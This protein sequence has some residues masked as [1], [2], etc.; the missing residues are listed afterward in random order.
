[1]NTSRRITVAR[2]IY[3]TCMCF[4]LAGGIFLSNIL[5]TDASYTAG[6]TKPD[7]N[8]PS[9]EEVP[10]EHIEEPEYSYTKYVMTFTGSVNV[11]SMFG[12]RSYGTL[13][14]IHDE[15]GGAYFL[16]NMTE[17]TMNDDYTLAFLSSVFSDSDNLT[18]REKSGEEEIGWYRASADNTDILSLG[19]IDA[20]SLE[21]SG[22]KDYGSEG[23][24]D[25]KKAL[26][27]E[28]IAWGDSGKALYITQA[29]GVDIALY[30]CTYNTENVPGIISWIESAASARDYVAVMIRTSGTVNA[31]MT[32]DFH[33][34]IDAGADLIVAT[35]CKSI[36]AAENYG[37][38]Y[39]AYSLGSLIN[40]AEKYGDEYSSVLQVEMIIDDSV[41]EQVNYTILPVRNYSDGESWHPTP[42]R[43][44]T[45]VEQ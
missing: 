16:E 31:E 36:A 15:K 42:E 27:N 38:G 4:I 43:G 21:C 34:F 33:A 9:A 3:I 44:I 11:G 1:M 26:E 8:T 32:S 20:V 40:G 29:G 12:S 14:G 22:T 10:S 23:Y 30:P 19:G 35:N 7:G 6:L 41:I 24:S 37:N 25:T 39:I 45:S 17:I 28:G 13:G 5:Y 2:T 18:A